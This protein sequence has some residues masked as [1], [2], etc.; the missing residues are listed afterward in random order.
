MIRSAL[1]GLIHDKTIRSPSIAYDNGESTT[2]MSTDAQGLDGIAD[3]VHETW[4]QVIEVIIGVC[5]LAIEV[6]WVLLLPVVLIYCKLLICCLIARLTC[7]PSMFPR[8]SLC[9]KT[10]NS[11]SKG[12]EQSNSKPRRRHKFYAKL[13][14]N[15][16]NAWVST[17]YL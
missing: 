12:M 4:A 11:S 8:E 13:N 1:T 9:C 5:L 7:I 6:G 14:E 16:K 10:S 17:K 2:L 15:H 3:M